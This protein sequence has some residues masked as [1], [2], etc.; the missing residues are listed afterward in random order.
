M[1]W[2]QDLEANLG[3]DGAW[4][5]AMWVARKQVTASGMAELSQYFT[6]MSNLYL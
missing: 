1:F 4:V 3:G 6:I 5:E 2:A